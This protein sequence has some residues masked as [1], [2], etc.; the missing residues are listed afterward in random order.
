MSTLYPQKS[1]QTNLTNPKVLV[2]LGPTSS[3]KSDLAIHLAQKF[4]GEVI[5]VDSRQVYK[6]MDLGTGKV[7]GKWMPGKNEPKKDKKV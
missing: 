6:D 4:N 2:I 7:E 3:G 5:S 1:P